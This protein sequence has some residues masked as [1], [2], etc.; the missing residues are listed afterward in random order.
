MTTLYNNL[1]REEMPHLATLQQTLQSL[2]HHI[3]LNVQ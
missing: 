2:E 3:V 1:Y